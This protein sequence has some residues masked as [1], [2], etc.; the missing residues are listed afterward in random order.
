MIDI[1]VLKSGLQKCKIC[2]KGL[3]DIYHAY[4]INISIEFVCFACKSYH[5]SPIQN[6]S[7]KILIIACTTK[8]NK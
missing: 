5:N 4:F 8:T 3:A 2:L 7:I 1:E 6:K